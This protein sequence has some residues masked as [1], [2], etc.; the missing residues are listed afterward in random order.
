MEV[1][2]YS[3]EYKL[4]HCDADCGYGRYCNIFWLYISFVDILGRQLGNAYVSVS[5]LDALLV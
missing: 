5:W 4:P 1:Q 2:V 3:F